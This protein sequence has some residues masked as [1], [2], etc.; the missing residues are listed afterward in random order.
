MPNLEISECWDYDEIEIERDGNIISV[1]IS[2]GHEVR[3]KG[4]KGT[5]VKTEYDGVRVYLP[6][7]S[8]EGITMHFYY[9][10][11]YSKEGYYQA[12]D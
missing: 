3:Y 12:V 4:H 8:K 7:V 9:E 5:V 11:L 6:T 10:D 2:V 1:K